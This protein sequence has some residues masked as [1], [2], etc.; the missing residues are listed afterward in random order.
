MHR[1][2]PYTKYCSGKYS[3]LKS[4]EDSHV[5][6]PMKISGWVISTNERSSAFLCLM[7]QKLMLTTSMLS[8][9]FLVAGIHLTEL[10]GFGVDAIRGYP[11]VEPGL[12]IV[13]PSDS[14][15]VDRSV[16]SESSNRLHWKLGRPLRIGLF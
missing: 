4:V 13:L 10:F 11:V 1:S 14:V 6:V 9:L 12:D 16:W 2:F 15:D 8:S 7:L 5:S 3:L